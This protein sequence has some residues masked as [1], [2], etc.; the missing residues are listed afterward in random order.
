MRLRTLEAEL[1]FD[2]N[3][4][5]AKSCDRC[6]RKMGLLEGLGKTTCSHCRA[7]VGAEIEAAR[8]RYA[9]LVDGV[10]KGT[11]ALEPALVELAGVSTRT[12]LKPNE[13]TRIYKQALTDIV[14]RL[15]ADEVLTVDEEAEFTKA[16][17]ALGL[18]TEDLNRLD[19]QLIIKLVVA[20][21][22]AG[23]LDELA[24]ESVNLMRKR[25][26]VVYIEMPV[27]LMKEVTKREYVGAYGGLSFRIAKGVRFH[28]GGVRGHSEVV[29]TELQVADAGL[30]AITSQRLAFM[31]ARK[32]MEMPYTKLLGLNVF[33]DAIRFHLSNRQNA[34]LFK[35]MSGELVAALVNAAVQKSNALD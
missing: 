14:Q 4:L 13:L 21:A 23:R 1:T 29:G 5:V 34:P 31:G 12:G 11:M 17:G 35:V 25:G 30:L 10:S 7:E 22:N 6:G 32:T 26:E 9:E 8:K 18:S 3:Q 27:E 16:M 20:K 33:S 28:T 15:L 2:Q 24:D 19:Q